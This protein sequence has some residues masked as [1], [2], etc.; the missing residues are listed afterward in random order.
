MALKTETISQLEV[1]ESAE[2]TRVLVEQDGEYKRVDA[3]KLGGGKVKTVNG[4]EPDENGNVKVEIPETPDWVATKKPGSG[5]IVYI[6][7]QRLTSGMWSKLQMSLQPEATYVVTLNGELY[8]C[9]ARAYGQGAILGNNTELTLNDYPFCI[10]WAGGTAI[11]GMFFKRSDISYPVTLKVTNQGGYVYDKMPEEYLPDGVV[12]SVNGTEPDADGNVEIK[13]SGGSGVDVT[14]SVGQTIVVEEVDANGKPTKWKAAEYQPRTHWVEVVIEFPETQL[15]QSDEVFIGEAQF[16]ITYGEEYIVTYNGVKYNCL[17]FTAGE[18]NILG[19]GVVLG[20]ADNGLPFFAA[21]SG[22][23]LMV[24]PLDGA[25]AV[26]IKVERI[27]YVKMPSQYINWGDTGAFY[28][29]FDRDE[30]T[31]E[32]T[33]NDVKRAIATNRPIFARSGEYIYVGTLVS[34]SIDSV[35]VRCG[36][37]DANNSNHSVVEFDTDE[38]ATDPLNAPLVV[39]WG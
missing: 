28:I 6:A 15:A 18:D 27:N 22:G 3:D 9:V 14:A 39:M 21:V 25:E 29:D 16:D 1:L 24:A 5:D 7:E 34:N 26:T 38:S 32:I 23:G 31:T 20:L 33:P 4:A 2:G 17:P 19:N 8:P 10:L 11:S 13:V 30:M 36:Y 35:F 37:K 12:K